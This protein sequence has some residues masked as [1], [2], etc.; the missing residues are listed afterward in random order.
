MRV[1][2]IYCDF[3][4]YDVKANIFYV[5]ENKDIDKA[6]LIYPLAHIQLSIIN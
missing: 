4:Y 5:Y 6:L 1:N 3:G 2:I